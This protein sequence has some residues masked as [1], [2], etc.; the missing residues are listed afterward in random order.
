MGNQNRNLG[1]IILIV[2]LIISMVLSNPNKQD[3]V[4][5]YEERNSDI[6]N[7]L[8]I[9]VLTQSI[10]N[11]VINAATISSNYVVFSVYRNSLD[12][13][14]K[15]IGVFNNFIVLEDNETRTNIQRSF[16]SQN[17]KEVSTDQPAETA[18]SKAYI[19]EIQP[20]ENDN[21]GYWNYY[22]SRYGFNVNYPSYFS[23]ANPPINGDGQQF[24][25]PDEKIEITVYGCNVYDETTIEDE[26]NNLLNEI[27]DG[28]SFNKLA[29]EWFVVSWIDEGFIYY[30]KTFSGEGS[31]NTLIARY[32]E[33]IKEEGNHIVEKMEA[34]FK[35]GN[36]DDCH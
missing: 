32:Q 2:G 10:S 17:R 6:N 31:Q 36:L 21:E 11:R 23:R 24:Y 3:F 25:S 30:Q 29:D 13:D 15:F 35:P 27:T 34:S 12:P 9:N 1:I 8:A 26:Y 16:S 18:S 28:V 19:P 7:S 5:Y 14:V 20:V 4:Q 22:N 33:E